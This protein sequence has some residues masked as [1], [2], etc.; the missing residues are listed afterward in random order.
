MKTEFIRKIHNLFGKFSKNN[1]FANVQMQVQIER[2]FTAFTSSSGSFCPNSIVV[3]F[4]L[5]NIG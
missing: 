4:T 1:L 2:K 5:V 3:Y